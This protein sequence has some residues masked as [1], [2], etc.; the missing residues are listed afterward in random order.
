M[1]ARDKTLDEFKE[2]KTKKCSNC[3]KVKHVN[4][5]HRD[6]HT[7]DG[8]TTQ[9]KNCR[10]EHYHTHKERIAKHRKQYRENNKEKIAEQQKHYREV[11]KEKIA[12]KSKEYREA[13]KEKIAERGKR[14]REANKEKEAARIKRWSEANKE[15]VSET[16]KAYYEENKEEILT[17]QKERYP[18]IKE[19]KAKESKQRYHTKRQI[20]SEHKN[21]C[22][23]CGDTREHVLVF[24]H[25]NPKEKKF[26]IAGHNRSTVNLL[27]EIKKCIVLCNNCHHEF[28]HFDKRLE[29]T[30]KAL[31]EKYESLG[32]WLKDRE[33]DE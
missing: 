2:I 19:K 4:E 10:N 25:K 29:K 28:H 3:G 26:S 9:C 30:P 12:E 8:F 11:N 1:P 21:L 22:A 13:N 7:I 20:I 18:L 16:G 33:N 23:I 32:I 14:Y 31:L 6:K 24:H 27:A 5:F 15:R 17:R